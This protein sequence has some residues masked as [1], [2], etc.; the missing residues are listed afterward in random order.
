M[1]I[2]IISSSTEN[3]MN[4]QLQYCQIGKILKF[5]NFPIWTIP[6]TSNLKNS[7]NFQFGNFQKFA[8][9]KIK[10]NSI[11]KFPKIYNLDN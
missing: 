5:L 9:C 1:K 4:E 7:K 10:K 8:I 11:W 6:K 3:R 2:G